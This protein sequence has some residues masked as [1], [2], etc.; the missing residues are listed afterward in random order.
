MLSAAMTRLNYSVLHA[1]YG[2]LFIFECHKR[3][4]LLKLNTQEETRKK[5]HATKAHP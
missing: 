3:K 4:T 5:R 2:L 1:K